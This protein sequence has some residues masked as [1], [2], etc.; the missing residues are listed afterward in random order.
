MVSEA[1][2]YLSTAGKIGEVE[3]NDPFEVEAAGNVY[4]E[5][6]NGAPLFNE[7]DRHIWV[8]MRGTSVDGSIVY[9]GKGKIPGMIYWNGMMWGGPESGMIDI[10]RNEGAYTF[11]ALEMANRYTA[12]SWFDT[13][14]YFPT[15]RLFIDTIPGNISIEHILNGKG[16]VDIQGVDEEIEPT[17]I[18]MNGLSDSFTWYDGESWK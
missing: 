5:A 7:S 9:N 13:F 12:D 18:D 2:I 6:I 16:N 15:D 4:V 10:D 11:K 3:Q 1:N 14:L 8:F 17:T